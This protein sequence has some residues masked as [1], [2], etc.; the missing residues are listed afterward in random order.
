[1]K[2]KGQSGSIAYSSHGTDVSGYQRGVDI[3]IDDSRSPSAK[4]TDGFLF[5]QK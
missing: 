3:D 5:M 4:R 1:M 2:G